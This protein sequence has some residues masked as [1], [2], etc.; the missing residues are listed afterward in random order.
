MSSTGSEVELSDAGGNTPLSERD[1]AF[2]SP[3]ARHH[4]KAHT[5]SSSFGGS[6]RQPGVATIEEGEEL[7]S[8]SLRGS[9][10]SA[11][12]P[13]R[14]EVGAGARGGSAGLGCC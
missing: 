3:L 14:R 7:G 9:P 13:A 8:G 12:S 4:H 2:S 1:G 10:T 6:S 11:R 5:G